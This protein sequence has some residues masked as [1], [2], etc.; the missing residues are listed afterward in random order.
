MPNTACVC[1]S[2]IRHDA[3]RGWVHVDGGGAIAV[4]CQQCDWNGTPDPMA[5][6]CPRCGSLDLEDD[7]RAEPDHEA[8]PKAGV[9]PS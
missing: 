7:H 2:S 8:A 1:G 3:G 9:M 4:T 5:V 6:R